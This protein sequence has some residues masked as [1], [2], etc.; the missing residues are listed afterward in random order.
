[1]RKKTR[2]FLY[3]VPD[4]ILLNFSFASILYERN[5]S[6]DLNI[7]SQTLS[8]RFNEKM[9]IYVYNL[10]I[11]EIKIF[12]TFKLIELCQKNIFQSKGIKSNKMIE[13]F[14]I[15]KSDNNLT[16]HNKNMIHDLR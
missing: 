12:I 9:I 4:F 16:T 2:N 14:F 10:F 6:A 8:N 3:L 1:M 11:I 13:N 15:C 7:F 5:H